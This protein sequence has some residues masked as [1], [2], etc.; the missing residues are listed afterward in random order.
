MAAPENSPA[1]TAFGQFIQSHDAFLFSP[2]ELSPESGKDGTTLDIKCIR[3]SF[4][5]CRCLVL[6]PR[7]GAVNSFTK[8][9]LRKW[10]MS[11]FS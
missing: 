9:L 2:G 3:I 5:M 4:G 11:N 1:A 8:S 6:F 7:E 10:W